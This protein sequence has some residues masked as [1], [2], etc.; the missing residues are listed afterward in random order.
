MLFDL[1]RI[2]GERVRQVDELKVG[3]RLWIRSSDLFLMLG[4]AVVG[5]ALSQLIRLLVAGWVPYL[6][7]PLGSLVAWLLFSRKRSVSG[8]LHARRFDRLRDRR[9]G[10]DGGFV[11]PGEPDA[12]SPNGYRLLVQHAHPVY[13]LKPM[14]GDER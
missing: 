7:V 4:G 1:T 5:L 8:E 11:L 3:G 6:L 14:R 12:F 13:G 10:V 2:S 9:R